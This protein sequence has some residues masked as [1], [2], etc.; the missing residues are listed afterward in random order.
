MTK[1][2]TYQFDIDAEPYNEDTAKIIYGRKAQYNSDYPEDVLAKEYA[3]ELI[4]DAIVSVFQKKLS[5]LAE[6]KVDVEDLNADD[7]A[8]WDYLDRKENRYL[9]AQESLRL[10]KKT[11]N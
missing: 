3:Y 7:K 6:K 11:K 2:F 4:K 10:S 5:F 8:Y 9:K 1:T